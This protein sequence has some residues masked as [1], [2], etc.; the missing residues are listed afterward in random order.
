MSSRDLVFG[1]LVRKSGPDASKCLTVKCFEMETNEMTTEK[2]LQII[3]DA[4]A[5][6]RRDFE[7]NAGKPMI[8]WGVIV[9]IFSVLTWGVFRLTGA[10]VWFSLWFGVPVVGYPLTMLL[11]KKEKNKTTRNFVN[12][13]LGQVWSI[14]GI[15]ATA[16]AVAFSFIDPTCIAFAIAILIGFATAVTGLILKN[17]WFVAGGVVTGIA[18][19]VILSLVHSADLNLMFAAIALVDLLIPGLFINRRNA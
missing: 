8:L 12:Q 2:S 4:I 11:V 13:T 10:P 17:G 14:Y 5:K 1:P 3:G 19:P 18:C 16:L 6:S 15:F 7:K 9:M